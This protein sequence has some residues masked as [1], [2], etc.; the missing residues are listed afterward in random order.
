MAVMAR[1]RQ[2]IECGK[3]VLRRWQGQSDFAAAYTLIEESV[4]HLLPWE[5]WAAHH[6]EAATREFLAKAGTNW[7]SGDVYNYAIAADGG[8]LVGMCQSY[9]CADPRG[10]RMGYWLHPAATGRGIATRATAALVAE[11]FTLPEVEYLEIEHDLA[12]TSSAAVARRLGFTE[13]RHEPGE[14]PAPPAGTGTAV[15]WRLDRPDPES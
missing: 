5:P 10:R 11:M 15:I 4:E 6:G 3:F 13:L 2:T 12:N 14:P 8:V 1:P 9:R 7:A